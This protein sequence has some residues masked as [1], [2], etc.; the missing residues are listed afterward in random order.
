MLAAY[1]VMKNNLKRYFQNKT[2]YILTLLIPILIS[3]IGMISINLSTQEIKIGT[4]NLPNFNIE[5]ATFVKIEQDS[6]HTDYIIGK[7]DYILQG[8]YE[9]DIKNIKSILENKNNTIG[10]TGEKQ[11]VA[12]LITAYLVIATVYAS[13]QIVDQANK[14]LE[15]FCYAGNSRSNYLLGT[16]FSTAIIVFIQVNVALLSFYFIIPEFSYSLTKVVELGLKI[17]IITSIF[18][19]LLSQ[20]THSEMSANLIASFFSVFSSIIGGTFIAV[21]A[22]PKFLQYLSILSPIRWLLGN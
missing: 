18:A 7:Y 14:T 12:L 3:L 19:S 4:E 16:F 2:T 11:L 13:K 22:M 17:T 6:I 21:D 15:R 1:L 5:K 10:L 8:N 20:I 9:E